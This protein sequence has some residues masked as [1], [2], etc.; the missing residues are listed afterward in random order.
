MSDRKQIVHPAAK[1]ASRNALEFLS[2]DEALQAAFD[3]HGEWY[4]REWLYSRLGKLQSM[5][6]NRVPKQ[7]RSTKEPLPDN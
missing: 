1:Q 4:V 3:K 5:S 2:L 6:R 7:F